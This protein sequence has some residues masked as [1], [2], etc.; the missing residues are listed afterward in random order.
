MIDTYLVPQLTVVTAKGDGEAVD[1]SSAQ[2]RAFLLTLNIANVIEQESLDV[3]V[4]GSADGTTWD[5]KPLAVFQ[6]KFYR[7]E[8]PM[9]MD[10][11]GSADVKFVRAHWE[12]NRWGRGVSAPMFEFSL[13]LREVPAELLRE[14][15]REAASRS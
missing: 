9:L 4:V 1:I 14:V 11:S 8:T 7:G 10:L 12:V 3:A 5:P 13:Q 15:Q 2:N 6:Q